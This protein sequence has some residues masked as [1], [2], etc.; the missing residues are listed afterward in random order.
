MSAII[1]TLGL[2][3]LHN[4]LIFLAVFVLF[5]F[6]MLRCIPNCGCCKQHAC[7]AQNRAE[8]GA[9]LLAANTPTPWEMVRIASLF[10]EDPLAVARPRLFLAIYCTTALRWLLPFAFSYGHIAASHQKNCNIQS[11]LTQCKPYLAHG[12]TQAS[13][14]HCAW[15]RFLLYLTHCL[16]C[17][18][19]IV[20]LHFCCCCRIT[21]SLLYP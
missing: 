16:M 1:A 4:A 20:V 15:K 13:D 10:R 5:S 2:I 17:L 11:E 7:T 21:D 3:A 14:L 18:L 9:N 12:L 8:H 19:L 6:V